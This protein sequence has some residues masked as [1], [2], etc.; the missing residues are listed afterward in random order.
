MPVVAPAQDEG[1]ISPLY[2]GP[3][4]LPVP[5]MLDGRVSERFYVELDY[6]CHSGFYGDLTQ[7]VFASTAILRHPSRTAV[8]RKP[9]T[10]DTRSA[11]CMCRWTFRC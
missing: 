10:A 4:A 8:R 6:D 9:A 2:F 11:T 1:R 7:T 3:N 5:D